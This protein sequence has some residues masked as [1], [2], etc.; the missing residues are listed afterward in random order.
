MVKVTKTYDDVTIK[1]S[2][3]GAAIRIIL[4]GNLF[5]LHEIK[6]TLMC[7]NSWFVVMGD[8]LCVDDLCFIRNCLILNL[9]S[10]SIILY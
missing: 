10:T 8:V 6:R 7:G 9:L 3:K 4:P 1:K 5:K 2:M